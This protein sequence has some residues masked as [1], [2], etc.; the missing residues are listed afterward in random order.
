ML[1]RDAKFYRRVCPRVFVFVALS[2]VALSFC[3]LSACQAQP[4]GRLSGADKANLRTLSEDGIET[5]T[6][7]LIEAALTHESRAARNAA[8]REL[9]RRRETAALPAFRRLLTDDASLAGLDIVKKMAALDRWPGP[10][11][12]DPRDYV[13]KAAALALAEM[14]DPL[15]F[16]H[17][18]TINDRLA[19]SFFRVAYAM[20][21]ARLGDFGGYAHVA[22]AVS[23]SRQEVK[24]LAVRGSMLFVDLGFEAESEDE[25]P[26]RVLETLWLDPDPKIRIEVLQGLESARSKLDRKVWRPRV[27]A[28]AE[29]DADG[30]VRAFAERVL[31]TWDF[32]IGEALR[33]KRTES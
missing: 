33:R 4:P 8:I 12:A 32:R 2:F 29:K 24:I 1:N 11:D 10:G 26:V 20:D 31:S 19:D 7:S 3:G 22:A 25:D 21:R 23:D 13:R 6:K 9:V 16:H 30:E 14:G 27:E 5:D 17:L 15:G 28:A 18:P